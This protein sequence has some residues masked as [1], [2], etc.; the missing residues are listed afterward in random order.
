MFRL[1]RWVIIPLAILAFFT[2]VSRLGNFDYAAQK[3]IFTAGGDSWEFGKRS[4]W[5]FLYHYGTYPAAITIFIALIGYV[6]SHMEERFR[7]WRAVYLFVLLFGVIG[8]GVVSNLILKEYW[9]R[10]RPR[11]VQGLGGSNAFEKVL[12]IDKTSSGKSFPCGHATMGYF[13]LGGFFICRRYRRDWAWFFLMLGLNL[14]F[15]MGV[16]R[17]CQGG[18]YFSDAIWS[19]AIMWFIG[20][21]L[22]Y[23]LGLHKNILQEPKQ[24]AMWL[25]VVVLVMGLALLAGVLMASPYHNV[26]NFRLNNPANQTG[27]IQA[28]LTLR[29]GEVRVVGGD[30]F[31]VNG[32]AWGHGVPTSKV[33]ASLYEGRSG[34]KVVAHYYERVGGRFTEVSQSLTVTVPWDRLKSLAIHAQD[35]TVTIEMPEAEQPLAL[36]KISVDGA[37]SQVRFDQLPDTMSW[38]DAE[39]RDLYGEAADAVAQPETLII[40]VLPDYEGMLQ[41]QTID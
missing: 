16:G 1:F 39:D 14:G 3:T 40:D 23:I 12:T 35:C 18:H 4:L 31:M 25:R 21:G 6:R 30:T 8:P 26:R 38:A 29:T 27:P 9:G 17:M 7:R 32:E 15:F 37:D 28:S 19:G 24:H 33:G 5:H 34:D 36:Q 10:P 22:Y 20:L 13:F 2:W 41:L 11:E